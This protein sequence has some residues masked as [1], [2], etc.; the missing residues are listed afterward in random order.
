VAALLAV[1]SSSMCATIMR[2]NVVR[3]FIG[4]SVMSP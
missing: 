4:F 1:V 3:D 2:A